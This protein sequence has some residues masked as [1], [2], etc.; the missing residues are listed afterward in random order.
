MPSRPHTAWRGAI[1]FASFPV[2]VVLYSRVQK[3]RSQSFRNLAP[4]GQPVAQQM[5]DPHDGA[6][7]ENSAIR[8][9][10]DVGGGK[11]VVIPPE[12]IEAVKSGVKTEVAKPRQFVPMDSLAWDLAIDRFAVRPDD[13]V[14]GSGQSTGIIWNGLRS[15]GLAYV[16]QVSLTGGH[17]G[18]LALYADDQGF[19][20]ALLPFEE[21][22][23]P[24]PTHQFEVD[25]KAET[26][27]AQV[28]EA[29]HEIEPFDHASYK[30]EYRA[31][32]EA[33]IDQVVA[34][35][36]VAQSAEP[37]PEPV[38][39]MVVLKASV[40]NEKAKTKTTKKATKKAKVS[41]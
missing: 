10:V 16:T 2:N 35:E 18:I 14:P 1:E 22:L 8:K 21:E 5:V 23:Y 7:V 17:D 4:S 19:W 36:P 29:Q 25:E 11:F 20:A 28:L 39:L 3:Q 32:R 33:I 24:V 15:T 38:D 37:K 27:F 31:R 40:A 26:L 12:A 9:G 34:G 30:S 6:V 41:A 13:K